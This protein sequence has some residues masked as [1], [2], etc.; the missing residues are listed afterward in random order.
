[1]RLFLVLLALTDFK[2]FYSTFYMI[3]YLLGNEVVNP[4]E[5]SSVLI[6][7]PNFTA[8][9]DTVFD[10]LSMLAVVLALDGGIRLWRGL[11]APAGQRGLGFLKRHTSSI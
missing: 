2:F 1:M 4:G 6:H 8:W 9:A 3:G 11:L 7:H 5:F 10:N